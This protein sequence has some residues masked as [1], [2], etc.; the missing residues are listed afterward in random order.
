MV[1]IKVEATPANCWVMLPVTLTFKTILIKKESDLRR[2]HSGSAK[3][4]DIATTKGMVNR[5]R[6]FAGIQEG[7]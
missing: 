3:N 6:F 4:T 1:I 2:I 5:F 7:K